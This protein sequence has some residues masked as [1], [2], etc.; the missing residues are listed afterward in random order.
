MSALAGNRKVLKS[1]CSTK[2]WVVNV[3]DIY[4][5]EKDIPVGCV[6]PACADCADSFNGHQMLLLGG[7]HLPTRTGVGPVQWG[8]MNK[9]EQVSSDGWQM[10]LA[11]GQ[12]WG[13]ESSQVSYGCQEGLYREVK[14]I[15][16]NGQIGTSSCVQTNTHHT[17]EN[18][19]LLQLPW[20]SV[21]TVCVSVSH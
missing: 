21:T 9:F 18:I 8:L 3:N 6:P 14:C 17:C 2:Y 5:Q 1:K 15:M 12:G 20:Q 7:G 19:T 11:G 16:G 10:S 13:A 4:Q